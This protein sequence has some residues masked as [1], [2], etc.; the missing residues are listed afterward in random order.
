MTVPGDVL[1]VE[2]VVASARVDQEIDLESLAF[3]LP[4]VDSEYG[5][6]PDL[7]CRSRES[8]ASVLIF[9]SGEIVT[10]GTRIEAGTRALL[11]DLFEELTALGVETPENPH[12]DDPEHR[13]QC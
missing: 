7:V 12:G 5:R 6:F 13:Q 11:T 4:R 3:D 1:R 9:R 8:E 2:N 10:L